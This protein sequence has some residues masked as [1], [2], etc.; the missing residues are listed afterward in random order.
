MCVSVLT[1]SN[2]KCIIVLSNSWQI[3][4]LDIFP[5]C[6]SINFRFLTLSNYDTFQLWSISILEL[7]NSDTYPFWHIPFSTWH[8]SFPAWHVSPVKP[9]WHWHLNPPWVL[10]QTPPLWHIG[11]KASSPHSSMSSSQVGPVQPGLQT[12]LLKESSAHWW[13]D[14][15]TLAL[16]TACWAFRGT[17]NVPGLSWKIVGCK[18]TSYS[19]W[20]LVKPTDFVTG[21]WDI[22]LLGH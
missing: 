16:D 6:H 21:G 2:I 13:A 5:L 14:G 17:I 8:C 20:L 11:P 19:Y 9:A 3:P 12:Q 22:F 1:L 10:W 15:Y 7:S 4:T 18:Q